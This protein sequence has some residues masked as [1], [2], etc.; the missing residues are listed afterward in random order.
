[1]TT[2]VPVLTTGRLCL[3]WPSPAQIDGY[4]DAIINSN[5]FDTIQWE[6]P[7]CR[8]ELHDWWAQN[9]LRNPYDFSLDLNFA[10][11][12]NSTGRLIG[13]TG[14]RPVAGNHHIIN[15]GYAF[16][17]T[18][19]GKGYA[20]EAVGAMVDEAFRHRQAER[21]FGKVFVGNMASRRVME[22]LSFRLEGT[23]RRCIQKRQQWRDQWVL[24]ITRPDWEKL[25]H[26]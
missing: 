25:A 16:E 15:I 22:K 3:T 4:Y 14:L 11:I 26:R 24:A 23:H 5:I 20:T 12:E 6:G 13:G 10:V 7:S 2:T 1:M 21:V 19:Q 17:P 18:S 9:M 8:Q